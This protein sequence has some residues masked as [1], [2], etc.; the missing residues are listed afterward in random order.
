MT[1]DHEEKVHRLL[2][3]IDGLILENADKTEAYLPFYEAEN[4]EISFSPELLA[5]LSKPENT[6]LI[7]WAQQHIRSIFD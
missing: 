6:D 7:P 1:E 5:I 2:E 3:I 4:G